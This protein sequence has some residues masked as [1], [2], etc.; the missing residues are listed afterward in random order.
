MINNLYALLKQ[1]VE[2][3]KGWRYSGMTS[4]TRSFILTAMKKNNPYAN[5][6]LVKIKLFLKLYTPETKYSCCQVPI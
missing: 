3:R 4:E 2:E 5:C 6:F 1:E